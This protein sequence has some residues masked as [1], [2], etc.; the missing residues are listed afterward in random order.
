[1]PAAPAP[2]L[3]ELTIPLPAVRINFDSIPTSASV[4]TF[5]VLRTVDGETSV[6]RNASNIVITGNTTFS[7][8]DFDAPFGVPIT[9]TGRLVFG[10][11]DQGLSPQTSITLNVNT[12]WI[13]D[14]IDPLNYIEVSVDGQGTAFLGAESFQAVE[15]VTDYQ[16]VNV[17]GRKKPI[18]L[19]YGQKGIIGMEVEIY[20]EGFDTVAMSQLLS[21]SPLL[22]RVPSSIPNVPRF[23]NGSLQGIQEDVT[24]KTSSLNPLTRWVLV[25]DETEPQSL[26]IF[27]QVFDYAYWSGFYATYTDVLADYGASTYQSAIDTP[28]V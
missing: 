15:R 25:F 17:L 20:T 5:T 26:D 9:Y 27:F 7:I 1:M 22:I 3:T 24:W 2:T 14:P 28:P 10:T 6:V 19:S 12:I 21:V 8:V 4:T 18:L 23:L 11:A 13:T 16:L